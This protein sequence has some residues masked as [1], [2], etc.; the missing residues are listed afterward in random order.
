MTVRGRLLIACGLTT[1]T[2]TLGVFAAVAQG[3]HLQVGDIEPNR[4]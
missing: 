4:G 1:L 2:L 3:L